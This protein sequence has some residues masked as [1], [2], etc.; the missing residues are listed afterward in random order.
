[1]NQGRKVKLSMPAARRRETSSASMPKLRPVPYSA[2]VTRPIITGSAAQSQPASRR[3]RLTPSCNSQSAALAPAK[4]SAVFGTTAADR[5]ARVRNASTPKS[6]PPAKIKTA[7]TKTIAA[8]IWEET[9]NLASTSGTPGHPDMP[10]WSKLGAL[11]CDPCANRCDPSRP[12]DRRHGGIYVK[13]ANSKC[14]STL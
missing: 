14:R 1:M 4:P 5:S 10:P 8:R 13:K 12:P 9:R 11:S 7:T 2:S 6:Q 3:P